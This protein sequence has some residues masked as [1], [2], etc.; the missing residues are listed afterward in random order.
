MKLPF[1]N[2]E[3][4]SILQKNRWRLPDHCI[5][6]FSTSAVNGLQKNL[7]PDDAVTPFRAL[8]LTFRSARHCR[9]L[10]SYAQVKRME[11]E[12]WGD[13]G[14]TN[15][16]IRGDRIM[17]E[18]MGE[19]RP[20]GAMSIARPFITRLPIEW[21]DVIRL[22]AYRYKFLSNKEMTKLLISTEG[23]FLCYAHIND[24]VEGIYRSPAQMAGVTDIREWKGENRAGRTLMM[25]RDELSFMP[26]HNVIPSDGRPIRILIRLFDGMLFNMFLDTLMKMMRISK[27]CIE[28]EKKED[29][30]VNLLYY[31]DRD[32]RKQHRVTSLIRALSLYPGLE[33][34]HWED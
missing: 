34:I 1:P 28:F 20:N 23:S 4:A 8:D 16:M 3:I 22:I 14:I 5:Y 7:F 12:G 17:S 11:R 25:V 18:I 29:G 6:Y 27:G 30:L 21:V 9:A 2:K 10:L 33:V 19:E 31:I 24:R 32:K 15:A 13:S 26:F